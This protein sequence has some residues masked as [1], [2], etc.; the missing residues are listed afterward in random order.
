MS[1]PRVRPS[2]TNEVPVPGGPSNKARNLVGLL[3]SQ[4]SS[5]S[6]GELSRMNATRGAES[7]GVV[8]TWTRKMKTSSD[9]FPHL[10]IGCL[11]IPGNLFGEQV[12]LSPF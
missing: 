2:A 10:D 6:T 12:V 3:I 4:K 11:C 9:W 1:A 8:A 7:S 5:R